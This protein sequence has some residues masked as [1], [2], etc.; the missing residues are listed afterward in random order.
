MLKLP[1]SRKTDMQDRGVCFVIHPMWHNHID[2]VI[3]IERQSFEEPWID[4]AFSHCIC[5]KEHAA[6][7]ATLDDRVAGYVV[8]HWSKDSHQLCNIAVAPEFRRMGVAR[9]MIMQQLALLGGAAKQILVGVSDKNLAAHQFFRSVGF[10]AVSIGSKFFS[11]GDDAYIFQWRVGAHDHYLELKHPD[12]VMPD[13][14][15]Y[16][17]P[18]AR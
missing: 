15:K 1:W 7:V 14:H 16:G 9:T 11:N 17:V 6:F 4:R 12:Y 18:V 3:E 13:S 2:A 5:S 10:C 8:M